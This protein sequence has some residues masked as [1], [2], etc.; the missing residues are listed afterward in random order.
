VN[1][2]IEECSMPCSGS[3]DVICGADS[4]QVILGVDFPGARRREADFADL[5]ARIGPGY[6]FLRAR[7]PVSPCGQPICGAAYVSPWIES[8]RQDR[9]QV[10]AV[11]G[12]RVGGVYAAAIAEGI[13]AWQPMP[14]VILFDPHF[15]SSR[16]L[17]LEFNREISAISSLLSD[18]EI[19]RTTR[20][21]TEISS[22]SLGDVAFAAGKISGMYWEI[23]AAA[24]ERVGIGGA[25][26]DKFIIPFDS[27]VSWLSVA[28]QI[29]P[30]LVWKGSTAIMSANYPEL[31]GGASGVDGVSALIG[32]SIPFD[33]PD[34][35]LLRSDS[36]ARA[37]LDLLESQ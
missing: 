5:A 3:W 4:D 21:A 32:R 37:V 34:A 35:E 26:G 19:E 16:Y 12:Y 11:L 28:D 14:K 6:K 30:S 17:G 7:P 25:Y 1:L 10:V 24:F 33:V 31:A 20:T 36:V 13:A 2:F 27:Y 29:G 23:S 9:H 8:I 15:T 18:D 22:S